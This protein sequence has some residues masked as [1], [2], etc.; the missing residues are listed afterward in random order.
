MKNKNKIILV[1][2]M[3]IASLFTSCNSSSDKITVVHKNY[4]EQRIVGEAIGIFLE[5]KGFETEVK[6]LGGTLLCFNAI[7][8][9][10]ADMY[11]E[12]TGSA[13]GSIFNQTDN[14]GPEATYNYVKER[15]EE[16]YGITWLGPLGFN[17]TYVFSTTQ[18]LVDKYNLETISDL[19]PIADQLVLGGDQEFPVR[20]GD[21]LPAVV[22]TYGFEFKEYK[23]MDQGLTTQALIEGQIDINT[24]YSTDGRIAKYGFVN[25]V[26]DKNVFP[27]YYV[28][29]IMK[30]EYA[31]EHPEVVEA[32]NELTNK[33]T[34]SD[35]QKYNLMVDEGGSVKDAA[36][37]MLSDKG[38]I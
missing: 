24:Y 21:G 2:I 10:D 12:Y 17:D 27:P 3:A 18:E 38:L 35:M 22:R 29:P 26:D 6:E 34:E 33:F 14:I 30:T 16:E 28:T 36:T 11:C 9:G 19:A 5:S 15:C 20:E 37:K 31:D 7:K 23:G 32:L 25:L 4:T 13:Y 8:N 1:T